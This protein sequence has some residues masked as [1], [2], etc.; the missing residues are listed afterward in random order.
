M[1]AKG[2]TTVPREIRQHFGVKPGDKI[3]YE[4]DPDGSVRLRTRKVRLADLAG[5]LGKPLRA[6]SLEEIDDAIGEAAVE[7]A[8]R[9]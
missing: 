3:A 1:T 4:I 2:Q 8:Q 5:I 7:R 6:A 9:S